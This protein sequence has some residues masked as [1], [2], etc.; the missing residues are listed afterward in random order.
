[1]YLSECD[2]FE[3]VVWGYPEHLDGLNFI[4]QMSAQRSNFVKS[5]CSFFDRP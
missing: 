3:L 5:S 4:P 2:P 1:M